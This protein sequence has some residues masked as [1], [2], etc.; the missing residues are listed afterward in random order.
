MRRA[1]HYILRADS[2]M[3]RLN[4]LRLFVDGGSLRVVVLMV[5][6]LV[7]LPS[8]EQLALAASPLIRRIGNRAKNATA[9]ERV[10]SADS[11]PQSLV[12]HA[13]VAAVPAP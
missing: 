8:F 7:S 9:T 13:N 3:S 1:T 2:R 11:P 5:L 10:A 12:S 6:M 4:V